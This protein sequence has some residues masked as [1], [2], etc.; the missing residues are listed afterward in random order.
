MRGLRNF[1]NLLAVAGLLAGT[2]MSSVG[3]YAAGPTKG[4]FDN[5]GEKVDGIL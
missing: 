5:F 2:I 3:A 1:L 4:S